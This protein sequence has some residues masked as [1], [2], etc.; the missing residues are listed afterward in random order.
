MR[1]QRAHFLIGESSQLETENDQNGEQILHGLVAKAQSRS[2]LPLHLGWTHRKWPVAASEERDAREGKRR[3]PSLALRRPP[4]N[5]VQRRGL[6]REK[7]HL[8]GLR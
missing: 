1:Q 5:T 7:K 3:Y 4:P 8:V 6:Q 2:S